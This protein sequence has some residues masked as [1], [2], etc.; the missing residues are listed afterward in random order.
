[1]EED[2]TKKPKVITGNAKW[3]LPPPQ[4][5]GR[6]KSQMNLAVHHL[7]AAAY[8]ARKTHEIE[9]LN[10]GKPFGEFYTEIIWNVSATVF[11]AVAGL[12]ADVNEIFSASD[13]HFPQ[14]DKLLVNQIWLLIEE[15]SIL[16]KY[17]MVSVLRTNQG[18]NKGEAP[19]DNVAGLIKL[20][21][22]LVH[23][24]PEWTDEKREHLKIERRL[25]G[26][27]QLSPF[28]GP[29]DEFFPKRCM[30]HGCADWAVKTALMFRRELN[31]IAGLPDKFA[32]YT[33]RLATRPV[34]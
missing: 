11:F 13:T 31:K 12:E 25:T 4:F 33:A 23:F 34:E 8:S 28:L 26:K 16:E 5:S 21:N 27:F 3:V 10:A 7:M 20:R 1:M 30:S 18:L 6:A 19:Y 22:A 9:Q 17:D 2:Q 14:H 15:K 29:Q 32:P 24:K